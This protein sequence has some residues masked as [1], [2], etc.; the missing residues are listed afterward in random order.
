M[1]GAASDRAK[2]AAEEYLQ[3]GGFKGTRMPG[4]EDVD[5]D[6]LLAKVHNAELGLDRSINLGYVCAI[7]RG[8]EPIGAG[9]ITGSEWLA[10]LLERHLTTTP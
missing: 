1:N 5:L 4:T 2:A 3:F 6:T 9:R 10:N 7:L 8:K